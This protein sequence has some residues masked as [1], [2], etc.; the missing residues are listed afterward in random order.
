[1]VRDLSD[2]A[3]V[4]RS[5]SRGA[6]N[7]S[8]FSESFERTLRHT[9]HPPIDSTSRVLQNLHANVVE[10]THSVISDHCQADAAALRLEWQ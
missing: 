5:S 1:V 10:R 9:A 6:V 2:R 3:K 8:M 7:N 4:E